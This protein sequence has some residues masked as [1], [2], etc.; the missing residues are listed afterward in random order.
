[1][2]AKRI[3]QDVQNKIN[4]VSKIMIY[5]I[6]FCCASPFLYMILLQVWASPKGMDIMTYV[7]SDSFALINM[8]ASFINPFAGLALN[9][10]RKRLLEYGPA[11]EI[12]RGLEILLIG[13]LCMMNTLYIFVMLYL[14]YRVR[15]IYKEKYRI[16][17]RAP[18][19][20]E[21][22]KSASAS[23]TVLV[24]YLFVGI[25]LIRVTFFA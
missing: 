6:V 20:K 16:A 2:R 4:R 10:I 8:L 19:I 25:L 24:L 3:P 23:I 9:Q 22:F 11:D 17:W 21:F 18:S 12:Y 15:G 13:E 14:L 7:E 5:A 1:M